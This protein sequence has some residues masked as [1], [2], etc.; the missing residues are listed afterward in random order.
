MV[1]HL[2]EPLEFI[3][4]LGGADNMEEIFEPTLDFSHAECVLDTELK[5]MAMTPKTR[6]NKEEIPK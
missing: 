3:V 5:L 1:L 4:V 6:I 2:Q